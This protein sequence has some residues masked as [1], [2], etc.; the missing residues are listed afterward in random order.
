M[1][2][3]D[4]AARSGSVTEGILPLSRIMVCTEIQANQNQMW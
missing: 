4:E 3:G 1:S 2:T